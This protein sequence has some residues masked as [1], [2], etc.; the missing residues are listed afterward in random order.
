[1]ILWEI[2]P[3][4]P[5]KSILE[6]SSHYCFLS[7]TGACTRPIKI[8]VQQER[9]LADEAIGKKRKDTP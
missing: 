2:D 4:S 8:Y 7:L 3:Q 9:V 6:H 1:M 5:A